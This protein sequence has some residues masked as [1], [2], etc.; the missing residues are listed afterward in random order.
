MNYSEMMVAQQPERRES[1]C[2]YGMRQ[3]EKIEFAFSLNETAL[4]VGD[5]VLMKTV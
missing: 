1:Q 3:N 2:L 4:G 5:Q